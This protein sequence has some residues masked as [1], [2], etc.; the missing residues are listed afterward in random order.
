MSKTLNLI[1]DHSTNPKTWLVIG[2]GV[3]GIV[4]VAGTLRNRKKKMMLTRED[5]GAFMERFELLPSPK[6]PPTVARLPLSGLTFTVKDMLAF[7]NR[8][9][10][11]RSGEIFLSRL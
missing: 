9:L 3:A 6:P 7:I 4:I 2:V 8:F 5:F 10:F 1:K 11:L